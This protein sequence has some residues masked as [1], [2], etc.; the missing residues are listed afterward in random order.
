VPHPSL[1][2]STRV[3]DGYSWRTGLALA[4]RP[5]PS[6]EIE[7]EPQYSAELQPAQYVTRTDDVG[8]DPTYGRR[9]IFSD[10]ERRSFSVQTRLNVTFSP[11]FTLQLYAQPL[12]SSGIYLT[13]KQLERAESFDFDTFEQG[14]AVIADDEVSCSGGRS[15][16]S[17]GTRYIDTDGDGNADLS[18]ADRDFNVRSLLLNAVLRWEFR[19]GSTVFLV[20]QQSRSD[21]VNDGSFDFGRDV[22]Q[23]WRVEPENMFIVKFTYWLGL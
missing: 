8:Y 6:W 2:Y 23:L 14:Q 15:C 17:D 21:K 11:T 13:Y 20:W 7:L 18:F 22:S 5:T 10:L 3:Q 9:Y 19:P 16:L 12:V 4:F 1:N